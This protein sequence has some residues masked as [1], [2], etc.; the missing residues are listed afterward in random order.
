[1]AAFA[2]ED[3]GEIDSLGL[4]HILGEGGPPDRSSQSEIVVIGHL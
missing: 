2:E 4:P 3:I 1:M